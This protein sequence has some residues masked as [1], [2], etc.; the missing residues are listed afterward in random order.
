MTLSAGVKLGPYEIVS[1]LGAG[2]MGEVYRARDT[3]LDRDVAV[4]LLPDR[5]A[6]D[7]AMS[8]RFEREAK[9]VAALSHPNVLAVY[10]VGQHSGIAYVVTELLEGETLRQTLMDGALPTRKAIEVAVS[11]ADGL[12]AAHARGIVH[13]DLKPENI[14]LTVDGVVKILDFGLARMEGGPQSPADAAHTPTVTLNTSPGTI[15]GTI[16][17]MSPEQ[18]RA[19]RT[20]PRSDVFSFGCVLY[21]IL[22][23]DR[24][25]QGETSADTMTAI[26]RE[27]PKNPR[28]SRRSIPPELE[29]VIQRCLEKK[30]EARF[31]SSHDLA[32]TLRSILADSGSG[33]PREVLKPVRR[34]GLVVGLVGAVIVV[35]GFFVVRHELRK[36][37]YEAREAISSLAVL[38]LENVSRD[39][40]QEYFVDGMTEA[41]I[42]DLAKIGGLKVISRTSVMR[43]KA[44]TKSLPEIARELNVDAVVE[45]SVLRV[46]DRVR[47]TAQLI[48]AATDKHLWAESYDRDLRDVLRLQSEVART[49]A[50]E[51]KV[52]LTPQEHA[53]MAEARPINPEAYQAYL[54]GRFYWNKRTPDGL[55]KAVEYFEQAVALDPAWPLGYA[56]LAD[57]YLVMP[58]YAPVR[59]SEAIPKARAAAAKA[60]EMDES[61]AEAH[62]TMALIATTYDWNWPTAEREFQRALALSPNYATAHLWYALYF[63]NMGRHDEAIKEIT[64]AQELDPLSLLIGVNV[65]LAHYF[66]GDLEQAET[67]LR[68]TLEFG[69]DFAFAHMYLARILFLQGRL[70]EAITEARQAVR[71]SNNDPYYAA[72]LGYL[73]AKAGQADEARRILDELAA[74]ST[75]AYVAPIHFALV[76]AGLDERDRMFEWLERAYQERDVLLTF[77][78]P[79]PLLAPMRTDP[80]F[81]E[82]VRRVGLPPLSPMPSTTPLN[83]PLPR[84]DKGG[85]TA[86]KI[87]LAVLPFANDSGDSELDYLSDGIAETLI[88]GFSRIDGLNTVPRS[89]AFRHKADNADPIQ[90]GRQLSA[91]AILSG[92]VLKRADSLTIQAELTDVAEGRQLWG[93]RYQR[94]FDDLVEIERDI[95]KE[96][97]DALRLRLTGEEKRMLSRGYSENAEAY[98]LYLQGRFWWS[99]RT[100]EG[101]DNAL[102]LLDQAARLDP[103]FGL[104]HTGIADTYSLMPLYGFLTPKE[105]FTQARAAAEKALQLDNELAEAH[106]SMGMVRFYLQWDLKGGEQDFQRA[107]KL[108]P[109]YATTHQWYALNMGVQGRFSE[110]KSELR[111]A[112]ELDPLM[113]IFTHNFAWISYW[114]HDWT[115]MLSIAKSGLEFAPEFPWLQQSAGLALLELGRGDESLAHLRRAVELARSA[116][117]ASSYLGYGLARTGHEQEA[118]ALLVEWLELTKTHYVPP[119]DIA[120]MYV[121]L[122]EYEEAFQWLEKGYEV[123]DTWMLFLGVLPHWEPLQSDPRFAALLRRVGL[124]AIKRQAAPKAD[125]DRKAL[126]GE[127]P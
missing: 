55:Q 1:P 24:A 50:Q 101:F 70:A 77:T 26:L 75:E 68:K 63:R 54:K 62:A 86:G 104:A 65:G 89:T 32:F 11:V 59:P 64:K 28:S 6:S 40:E 99:K 17:Y 41:L 61:L 125:P 3:R 25:F 126:P 84:G 110:A 91:T 31:Q 69:P 49:I 103:T 117:F 81:A 123:R 7:P 8:A 78:L 108:N 9:V 13:R 22:T 20:D 94:K 5:L 92:R 71:L 38:P 79:D 87:T 114:E 4:K 102:R 111:R 66:A 127:S 83:P 29:R 100:K 124:P 116:S 113:P 57:A 34:T 106:T 27:A 95:A 90:V 88:N 58:N 67:W 51:I 21:E 47:I 112:I 48:H 35:G 74:R 43:Y 12:A 60:L 105:A 18:I 82:L 30:P 36:N 42:S 52:T 14:F 15:L 45:G 2:G 23:G 85:L 16:N 56:G 46:G 53:R 33:T 73:G 118:R 76:H 96:I 44:T 120:M 122:G 10:D 19:Q 39:P 119:S 109:R 115:E 93:E 37:R 72:T 97:T 107:M 98:R 80:R 121:G